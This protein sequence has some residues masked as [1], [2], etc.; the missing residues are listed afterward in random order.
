M[1]CRCL[2]KA[3]SLSCAFFDNMLQ[4]QSILWYPMRVTY[5][6]EMMI[7]SHFDKLG[8][9][10]YV[11]MK[12]EMEDDGITVMERMV[13]AIHNLIFV[14][15]TQ[16]TI[17]RLK[18]E[19]RDFEPLRYIMKHIDNGDTQIMTVPDHEMENFMKAASINDQSVSLVNDSDY[20]SKIGKMVRITAGQFKDVVGVVKRIK[21]NRC[22]VVRIQGVAAVIIANVPLRFVE[23]IL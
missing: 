19:K 15:S 13:P 10:T 20:F 21:K 16:G 11:P 6:R 12:Y 7:K 8:I 18:M 2:N 22:V 14:H 4:S 23:E 3:V 9:E 17:T 1:L 5:N